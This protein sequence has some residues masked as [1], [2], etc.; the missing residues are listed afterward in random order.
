MKI[1]INDSGHAQ[2]YAVVTRQIGVS[3]HFQSP[4]FRDQKNTNL[5][6]QGPEPQCPIYP[7]LFCKVIRYLV[8]EVSTA[9]RE[10]AHTK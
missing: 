3:L 2:N 8:I 7:L 10:G 9:Q 1:A 4:R 5:A 6:G